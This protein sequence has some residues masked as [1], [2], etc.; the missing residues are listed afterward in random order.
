MTSYIVFQYYECRVCNL[1]IVNHR[2][3]KIVSLKHLINNCI[4]N[5]LM[6]TAY[7]QNETQIPNFMAI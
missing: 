4:N 5:V 1:H 7:C 6:L 3:N 2:I